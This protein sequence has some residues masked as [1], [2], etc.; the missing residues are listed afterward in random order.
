MGCAWFGKGPLLTLCNRLVLPYNLLV[1]LPNRFS[2]CTALTFINMKGN[3]LTEVPMA[4][5][6]L[7]VFAHEHSRLTV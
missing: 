1:G 6:L 5:S 2:D 7:H 3:Q 4:V